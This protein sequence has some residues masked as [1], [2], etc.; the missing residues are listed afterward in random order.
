MEGLGL[1]I[2]RLQSTAAMDEAEGSFL[3]GS[4][5]AEHAPSLHQGGRA[6]SGSGDSAASSPTQRDA[7]GNNASQP[8]SLARKARR[9]LGQLPG[10]AQGHGRTGGTAV[11]QG[12][13]HSALAGAAASWTAAPPP[14][15]QGSINP[16]PRRMSQETGNDQAMADAESPRTLLPHHPRSRLR[17]SSGIPDYP[18]D[19][20]PGSSAV[21]P[22]A[23]PPRPAPPPP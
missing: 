20:I 15:M 22:G 2:A 18:Q 5:M 19:L 16:D 7:A 3:L 4:A 12:S 17:Q 11:H 10:D 9:K 13:A 21:H 8:A 23:M 14:S 6:Q 1:Q